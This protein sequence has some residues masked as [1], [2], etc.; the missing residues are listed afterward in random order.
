M[1]KHWVDGLYR[2]PIVRQVLTQAKKTPYTALFAAA[3]IVTVMIISG[4]G[5]VKQALAARSAKPKLDFP[6]DRVVV[7]QRKELRN[8]LENKIAQARQVKAAQQ[9][10]ATP[11]ASQL[12]AARKARVVALNR[13]K[14]AQRTTRSVDGASA[15]GGNT[16]VGTAYTPDPAENGGNNVTATGENLTDLLNRGEKVVASN[17]YKLGTKL[18]INGQWY[19][20]KDRMARS[21]KVDFLVRTKAEASKYGRQTI[22]IEEVK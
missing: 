5:T 7:Q 22:N 1:M 19:T 18:K 15:R 13:Q 20:V 3:V 12:V 11:S 6:A 14:A 8:E 17:D 4:V 2:K 21:G 10:V 16:K 9:S